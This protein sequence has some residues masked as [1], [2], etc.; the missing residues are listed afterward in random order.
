V[1][2]AL[3]GRATCDRTFAYFS[4][5]LHTFPHFFEVKLP[6]I[7]ILLSFY[8]LLI[9]IFDAIFNIKGVNCQKASSKK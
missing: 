3:F 2:A 5:I 4:T 7:A 6:T 9:D 1:R 8:S